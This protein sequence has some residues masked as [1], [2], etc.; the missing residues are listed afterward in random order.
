MPT[1][2]EHGSPRIAQNFPDQGIDNVTA[3]MVTE[4]DF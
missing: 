2:A 4:L 1:F 3:G